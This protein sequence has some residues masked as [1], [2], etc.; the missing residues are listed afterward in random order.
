MENLKKNQKTVLITSG[1]PGSGKSTLINTFNCPVVS[2]D[3]IR[4]SLLKKG[5]DYF[6]HE[7][8]VLRRFAS[9]I[10]NQ[11][12]DHDV[13]AIDATHLSPKSRRSVL[14][15][16][17]ED[18]DIYTIAV[19]VE[20]PVKVA[21]QRNAGRKGRALV[22]DTVIYNMARTYTRP[23]FTEGF[24]E[25]WVYDENLIVRKMVKE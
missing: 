14:G 19:C 7:D 24:D 22:P 15:M 12:R 18:I 2:R 25:I 1:I 17:P 13:I 20:V 6:A 11:L 3:Q 10:E 23:S 16:I 8:E 21:M 5:D 4:F 9:E